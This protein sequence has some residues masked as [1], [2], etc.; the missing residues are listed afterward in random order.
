VPAAWHSVAQRRAS[1]PSAAARSDA[2]GAAGPTAGKS[3]GNPWE[4]HGKSMGNPSE[5][6]EYMTN[7]MINGNS[8]W[9]SDEIR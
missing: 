7:M 5:Y 6:D 8:P 3:M 2:A 4:I 1:P 9:K